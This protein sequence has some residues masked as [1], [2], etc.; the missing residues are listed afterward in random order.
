MFIYDF[1]SD[2]FEQAVGGADRW[3]VEKAGSA[4]QPVCTHQQRVRFTS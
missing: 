4:L 3:R 1:S 2:F